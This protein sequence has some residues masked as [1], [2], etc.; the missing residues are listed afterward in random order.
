MLQENSPGAACMS[1]PYVPGILLQCVGFICLSR[2]LRLQSFFCLEDVT[3][4]HGHLD[5]LDVDGWKKQ[6]NK[7]YTY[8]A[9]YNGCSVQ[10]LVDV[11]A[12]R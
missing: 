4:R 12:K 2:S 3:N 9:M 10:H 8:I 6:F 7:T 1:G 5:F 11:A